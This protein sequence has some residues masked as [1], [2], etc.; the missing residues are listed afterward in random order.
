M[1][2]EPAV[3]ERVL[4]VAEHNAQTLAEFLEGEGYRCATATDAKNGL[5][6]FG[7]QGADLIIVA[8]E[9]AD[10]DGVALVRELKE[11]APDEL[12][13]P[14]IML[15]EGVDD[16]RRV[17]A[18]LGGADEILDHKVSF[19]ELALRVR[20]MLQ[21]RAVQRKLAEANAQLLEVQQKKQ[22]LAALVVHDLR[23][24]LSAL[25]GNVE[26]LRE[27][28]NE[29][30]PQTELTDQIVEDCRDL[31]IK[32]L[33]MVA[34]IL[35]VEELEEGLLRAVP[36]PTNILKFMQQAGRHHLT[37]VKAR[38]LELVYEADPELRA[39]VDADLAGR[40][41]ENLLDNAV[42]Y[43]PY[44]GNVVVS[45]VADG[46]D[47]VLRVGNNGP[48]VPESERELI[49][50][51]FYRIEARRAGARA[52][53]GLGLYFC[54]LVAEAHDGTIAIES[55]E[56]LPACFVVRFPNAML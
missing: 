42:R 33:S 56:E 1:S 54:K 2:A 52:N 46:K 8:A 27:E 4:I 34:G 38:K 18:L 7:D 24:P 41:V 48:P 6:Y 11:R 35:D 37:T 17:A 26:L 28:L 30:G 10:S 23:N 9:L 3:T 44:K 43:A 25:H 55:T 49:F 51:R 47:L 20:A 45:A 22:I 14:L 16:E 31:S 15:V 29:A 32:A 40:M 50:G 39:H 13:L 36:A 21:H 12:F 19:T 53:R 5:S